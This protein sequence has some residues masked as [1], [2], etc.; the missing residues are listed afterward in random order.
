MNY[1][2][3]YLKAYIIWSKADMCLNLLKFIQRKINALKAT[4]KYT[5]GL[6]NFQKPIAWKY[7]KN[8]NIFLSLLF[9]LA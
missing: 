5:I 9:L 6:Y 8:H 2:L 1:D 7:L 4:T 3:F